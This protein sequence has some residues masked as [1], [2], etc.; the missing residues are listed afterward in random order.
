MAGATSRPVSVAARKPSA[1]RRAYSITG[2]L[3]SKLAQNGFERAHY[4]GS[5]DLAGGAFPQKSTLG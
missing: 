3:V 2:P 4:S 5:L 1:K